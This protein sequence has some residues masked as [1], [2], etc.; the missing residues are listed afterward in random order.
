MAI[1]FWELLSKHE[2]KRHFLS[3]ISGG[4]NL[5]MTIALTIGKMNF[6]WPCHVMY[7]HEFTKSCDTHLCNFMFLVVYS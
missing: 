4:L 2:K 7:A 5:Y 6:C 3:H 1:R